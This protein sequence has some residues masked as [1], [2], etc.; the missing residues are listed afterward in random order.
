MMLPTVNAR[1]EAADGVL[2]NDL[3]RLAQLAQRTAVIAKKVRP[4]VGHGTGGGGGEAKERF[5]PHGRLA[6]AG[7]ADEAECLARLHGKADAVD[8]FD[9]ADGAR[10]YASA[11]REISPQVF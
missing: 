10:K 5:G 1:I 4:L 6:A 7:F 2:E 9:V 11:N 8:R 3:H